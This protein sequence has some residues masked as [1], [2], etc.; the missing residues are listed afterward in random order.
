MSEKYNY[1]KISSI[2]SYKKSG[3]GNSLRNIWDDVYLEKNQIESKNPL[4]IKEK[5]LLYYKVFKNLDFFDMPTKIS[6]LILQAGV[7]HGN[8]LKAIIQRVENIVPVGLDIS[9]LSLKKSGHN[10]LK[11]LL[12]AD[13]LNLPIAE[14]K[15]DAVFE[16]GV[17]EH[18]YREDP[19]LGKI[20]DRQAIIESLLE[21]KRVLKSKGKIGLIQ[22]SKHSVLPW[23]KSID[24]VNR[25]W[26]M[27]FQEDF[28]LDEFCQLIAIAGFADIKFAIL[29]A[30]SDFPLRIRIG[31]RLLKSFYTFT[32]QHKKAELT[33]ALFAVVGT[34]L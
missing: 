21:I 8:S 2:F 27:G 31:D 7:G 30:P 32:G 17:V 6:P 18:L 4:E 9:F 15:I 3:G 16:V 12:Q 1:D 25:R 24:M 28:A 19:F 11:N 5:H 14:N 13:I 20:V 22:P 10:G 33:G 34:K 23:S 29:Q 26:K